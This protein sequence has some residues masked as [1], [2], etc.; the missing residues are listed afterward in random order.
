MQHSNI[1]FSVNKFLD[2]FR[3]HE[4]PQKKAPDLP[5]EPSLSYETQLKNRLYALTTRAIYG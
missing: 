5:Q 1:C 2:F 4:S 3:A